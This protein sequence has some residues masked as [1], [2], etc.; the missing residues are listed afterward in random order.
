[1][2]LHRNWWVGALVFLVVFFIFQNRAFAQGIVTGNIIGVVVDSQGAV[3]QKAEITATNLETGI[4]LKTVSQSDG[5]FAFHVVPIGSYRVTITDQGFSSVTVNDVSVGSGL[6]ADL[7]QVAMHAGAATQTVQVNGSQASL[8]NPTQSQVATTFSTKQVETL[9]LNNGFD[10][11]AEVLPGVVSTHGDSYSNSNGD[12]F[13]VNGQS[14]RANN[15]ELD[16][17]SNNDNSVAGPQVFFGNQDAIAQIQIITN[18]FSAQYGR[19]AGAVVNYITK[20]GTNQIHGSAFEIYQGQALS[21]MTN[22]DKSPLFGYCLPGQNPTTANCTAPVLPR[23][24]ENRYG[25]T[26]GGPI[27]KNKLFA[28][29]STYWDRVR[30]G[31]SPSQSNP[32]LTPTPAGIAQ[33]EADLPNNPGVIALK[34]AGP[35]AI[36]AGN[37]QPIPGTTQ[38]ESLT[39]QG[40]S[41]NIPFS[42]MQ[43]SIPSL[44]NDEENL[45]RLD[46]QPDAKDH[47]FLRYFYQNQLS[48]GDGTIYSG[49][50][51]DVL[52]TAHSIGAD[53]THVFSAHWVDQ[54]RYSFQQTKLYFEGGAFPQCTADNLASCSPNVTFTGNNNDLGFGVFSNIPQGRTVKVT[55][56]QNNAT[57][58]YGN[59]TI[60]F[61]GEFDYQNSPNTFFPNYN[62]VLQYSTFQDLLQ[63]NG[64]LNLADGDPTIPFTEPDTALYFQDDWQVSPSFTANLGLRWEYFGQAVNKLHDESIARESNPNTA[65]WD[66]S[67]PL[68][69]RTV[70]KV[71]QNYRG[72]EPRIGFA[73]NPE[74]DKKLVVS[75]AYAINANPIFYNIFLN[76][77]TTTPISNSGTITCSGN[78]LPASGSFTGAALRAQ[79]L[80]QLP[81]GGN[82]AFRDQSYVPTNFRTPY[83]QTYTLGVRH[84]IGN[85][86]V[87]SI[88][89]TGVKTTDSFQAVDGNPYLE[90]VAQA[91]PNYNV[92]ASLCTNAEDAGYGRPNCNKSNL[93]LVTNGAWADYNGLGLNLTTRSYHGV[94]STVS[95]TYSDEI[96]NATDIY[97]SSS[98]AGV[99]MAYAQNPENTDIGERGKDGNSYPNVLG[100]SLNYTLPDFI[101]HGGLFSRIT[102]GFSLSSMYRYNSGQVYNATQPLSL[103]SINGDTSYCD[104]KFNS[105]SVGPHSDTCRLVLS[106]PKAPLNSVAYLNA[107]TGPLNSQGSP[108]LGSPVWVRYGT[109]GLNS[110]DTAYNPGSPI[111]P[112][113]AHWI[114]DNQAYANQ[115]GNPYPGS[116]RNILRG[117]SYS[118]LDMSIYKAIPIT[119]GI[120]M[121]LQF[122]GYNVLNQMYHGVPSNSLQ[123]YSATGFND[124]LSTAENQN[125]T[126]VGGSSGQRFFLYG[127]KITF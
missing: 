7:K 74:F 55:Q 110:A 12:N 44:S 30:N 18:S 120:N 90:P 117:G 47:M 63:D 89:Y 21:S 122:D 19:N 84:Q 8:L 2:R 85:S 54:L 68:A 45:G 22:G 58:T 27:L 56:V 109:D 10:T 3:I 114:V 125:A 52:D 33:L 112:S 50:F 97:G 81:R 40:K 115:V 116:G 108:T 46:W 92:G 75:A 72:F 23:Y 121:Q 11:I 87:F 59:Q 73:W 106:N 100:L 66:T 86:A 34:D 111:D 88:R 119:H 37:P 15:F 25:A 60:L 38:V 13:S 94:T 105:S 91:F 29:G 20:S 5:S 76:L 78:C 98:G 95:Y 4:T 61:G 67:L 83:V 104:S 64:Q 107:Y 43:R 28:F 17:Q 80:A 24:V 99:S 69:D 82:P 57:V 14:G 127:G 71:N 53:W 96:S 126:A 31:V 35:Y 32:S 70:P 9:P 123:A 93:A 36:T 62:G 6:T 1:M 102:N 41:Y 77:V 48:T 118:D 51:Y 39:V 49:Q 101:H 103:D 79:D 42:Y 65:F 16:G 113:S 26:L 124:F